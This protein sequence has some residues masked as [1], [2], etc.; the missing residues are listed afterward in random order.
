MQ[1]VLAN[2][3]NWIH[4]LSPPVFWLIISGLTALAAYFFW[5]MYAGLHHA[6]LIENIPTARIRSAHQGYIELIGRAKAMDGPLIVSPLSQTVCLWYRFKIEEK[7]SHYQSKGRSQARWRVVDEGVSDELFMLSD[8]T[9]ECVIDPDDAL[10]ISKNKK[11][12]YKHDVIPPRRYTEELILTG[13][14]FYAMGLFSTVAN[15]ED[16]KI[17]EQVSLKL[18]EWKNDPNLML[19]KYDTN[20]DGDIS[21]QEWEQARADATKAVKRD[22]GQRAKMKQLSMMQSSPH[23][24]QPYIL[25]TVSEAKLIRHYRRRGSLA[26]LGF[27]LVGAV[28]VWAVNIRLGLA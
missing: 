6:R 1:D 9:G 23:R 5:R 24:D 26:M 22:I 14:D 13:E 21:A 2:I 10:V 17:R 7:V 3:A 25:S 8:D 19:H 11:S 12:W 18:R 27:L 4:Q 28:L 20:A 16:N 15:V